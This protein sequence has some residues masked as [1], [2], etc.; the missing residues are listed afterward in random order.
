MRTCIENSEKKLLEN[1][2]WLRAAPFHE[3]P[4]FSS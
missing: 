2:F 1:Y 4:K 3:N